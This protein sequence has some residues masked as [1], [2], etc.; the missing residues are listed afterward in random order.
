MQTKFWW[1]YRK[2]IQKG[3]CKIKCTYQSSIIYEY[4][5]K[6]LNYEL[7]FSSQFNYC[8]LTWTFHNASL[9]HKINRLHERC[10]HVIYNDSQSSYDELLNL[11]NS[12]SI[13]PRNLQILATEMFFFFFFNNNI[14][15]WQ[16]IT[17]KKANL[18][19]QNNTISKT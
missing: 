1:S 19:K 18:G 11:D 16:K 3:W 2:Y 12:V 10:L 17:R 15:K 14:Y 4:R 13:H 7:L 6:V 9:N 8:P 5:K